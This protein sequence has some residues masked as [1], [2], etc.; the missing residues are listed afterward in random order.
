MPVNLP[1]PF[2]SIPRHS[3][4]FGPSPIQELP[5]ISSALGNGNVKVYAKRE[6]CNSGLAF[7]GNKI[8][9]LEYFVPDVLAQKCDTLVS[10]GMCMDDT[11]LP[12]HHPLTS[13][14]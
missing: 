6:D 4:T 2:A 10:I 12:L 3:L 11:Y 1:E 13:L 7:G 5:R 9:K 14:T 8:R